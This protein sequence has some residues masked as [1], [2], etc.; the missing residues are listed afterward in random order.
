MALICEPIVTEH[1]VSTE[2]L[3]VCRTVPRGVEVARRFVGTYRA[4]RGVRRTHGGGRGEGVRARRQP[5]A[6]P[7][8]RAQR[9]HHC[10]TTLYCRRPSL[11]SALLPYCPTQ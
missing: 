9:R 11:P 1:T 5:V 3:L 7:R 4:V 10:N 8:R 6:G 2:L